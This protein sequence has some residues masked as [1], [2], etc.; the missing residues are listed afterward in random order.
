MKKH[1]FITVICFAVLSAALVAQSITFNSP[2]PIIITGT[3]EEELIASIP[4]TNSGIETG[5]FHVKRSI[6]TPLAGSANWFCW[7]SNCYLPTIEQSLNAVSIIDG[8]SNSSFKA[9]LSPSGSVGNAEIRYTFFNAANPNDS[10]SINVQYEVTALSTGPNLSSPATIS[11]FPNPATE[12]IRFEYADLL[13]ESSIE[14]LNPLGK[15][16]AVI[17]ELALDGAVVFPLLKMSPG[18][19]FYRLHSKTNRAIKAGRFMVR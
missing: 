11:V 5:N 15:T 9:H 12:Y 17:N 7:G 14:I 13:T 18:I 10:S 1:L 16:I 2:G 4:V 6:V 3:S 8:L 19:Y